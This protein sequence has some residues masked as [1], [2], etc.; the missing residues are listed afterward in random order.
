MW[1]STRS[2]TL[3][4][5][6]S[7]IAAAVQPWD[8]PEAPDGLKDV[9]AGGASLTLWPYTTSD[10]ESPSDPLN[11]IF[12]NADPRAIRQ[13]L[14]KL[15]SS[16]PPFAAVPGSNCTWTDAMGYE[17]AAFAEPE[18]WVGGA[19]QLACATAGAPLGSPFRF[20]IRLF[21]QGGHTL[22]NAHFE[23]LIPGTAEHEV[24]SWDL[25][26]E[27]VTFDMGRTGVLTASPSAVGLVPAGSFRTVRRPVYLG[28]V[29][30]GAGGLLAS[31]G[32]VLPP[33]GDV[34]IPTSGQAR[35]LVGTIDFKPAPAKTTTTTRVTYSIVVP[36]PFCA[37]GPSD[38]VKLEG[39][40]DF[41]MTV[42]TNRSGRYDRT[43]LIG[44]TLQVTPM[45]PTSATSF[46]PVGDPVDAF[47]FEAHRGT[48][49]DGQGEVTERAAQV[50]LGE[51]RQSLSWTFAAG[52]RDY[53]ARQ[54]LCGIE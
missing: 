54:V 49:S 31:L 25:A 33:S 7:L 37:T 9:T 19:V 24:L 35:V 34:P 20:H 39:P 32:L 38:F 1:K 12:P 44:G 52:S 13:E 4:V 5:F 15:D 42:H 45:A 17:Q 53:F 22:G 11:L 51:P 21:R 16:R 18:G 10:F 40:R 28:L 30:A 27:L 36:K 23:F 14:L 46:V 3:A 6:M 8:A 41:S 43:Y 26:R 50:L 2:L 29:Q 48:L 47:V